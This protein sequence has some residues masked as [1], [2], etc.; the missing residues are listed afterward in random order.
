[1]E[2]SGQKEMKTISL[3]PDFFLRALQNICK[4]ANRGLI[5]GQIVEFAPQFWES[6]GTYLAIVLIRQSFTLF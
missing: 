3:L 2:K 4:H 6:K 1:M 5:S